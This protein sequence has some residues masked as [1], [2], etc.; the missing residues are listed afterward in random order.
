MRPSARAADRGVAD[1]GWVVVSRPPK[2]RPSPPR[3]AGAHG[4]A[5]DALSMHGLFVAAGPRSGAG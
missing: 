1:D 5:P 4:Y 2:G 3:I